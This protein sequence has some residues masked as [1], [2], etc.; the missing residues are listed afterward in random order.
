MSVHPIPPPRVGW[1]K[2]HNCGV[3]IL[4][5]HVAYHDQIIRFEE[6]SEGRWEQVD[7]LMHR[8]PEPDLVHHAE[9][10]KPHMCEP[11]VESSWA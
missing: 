11:G 3:E 10:Y 5:S 4:R 9:R 7:G 6:A 2:C 8:R 1:A